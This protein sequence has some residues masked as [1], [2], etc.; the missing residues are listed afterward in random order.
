MSAEGRREVGGTA[1]RT[2]GV[3]G[4]VEDDGLTLDVVE[5]GEEER[6]EGRE[7]HGAV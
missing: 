6:G 5:V 4:G 7:G 3:G 2:G 1:E